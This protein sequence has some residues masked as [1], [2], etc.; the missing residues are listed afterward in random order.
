[1]RNNTSDQEKIKNKYDWLSKDRKSRKSALLIF[2]IFCILLYFSFLS[3]IP[4][5]IVNTLSIPEEYLLYVWFFSIVV[6]VV[7]LIFSFKKT[8][9]L[10]MTQA[11]NAFYSLQNIH[12]N[13]KGIPENRVKLASKYNKILKRQVDLLDNIVYDYE[14]IPSLSDKSQ[15]QMIETLVSSLREKAIPALSE[16]KNLTE[17]SEICRLLSMVFLDIDVNKSRNDCQVILDTLPAQRR[18]KRDIYQILKSENHIIQ[19]VGCV[20]VSAVIFGLPL[21]AILLYIEVSQE[22]LVGGV[23]TAIFIPGTSLFYVMSKTRG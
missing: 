9:S 15:I 1:M 23:V 2:L 14:T 19:L 13:L 6:F 5:F 7:P 4:V 16:G 18:L 8:K 10:E 3:L 11:D 12:L 17:I 20:A 22:I 21:M